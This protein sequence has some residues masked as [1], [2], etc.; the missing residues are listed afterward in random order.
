M[1]TSGHAGGVSQKEV[2][3]WAFQ[4]DATSNKIV[5]AHDTKG[6]QQQ[7]PC[8]KLKEEN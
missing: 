4:S 1:E 3:E 7:S 2:G 5:P 6:L 8:V